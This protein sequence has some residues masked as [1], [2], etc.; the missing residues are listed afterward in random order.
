M[1]CHCDKINEFETRIRD[2]PEMIDVLILELQSIK[3][4]LQGG[5]M[6]VEMAK[7]ES[8]KKYTY[9]GELRDY[10]FTTNKKYTLME[11]KEYLETM[12]ILEDNEDT[13]D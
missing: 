1:T 12:K 8:V 11:Y 4:E 3:K 2:N 7:P 9:S 13:S 5:N 6:K 10:L